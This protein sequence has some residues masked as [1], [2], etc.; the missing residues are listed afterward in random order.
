MIP[1]KQIGDNLT[2]NEFNGVISLLRDNTKLNE[3]IQINTST[4]KGNYGEY[5]FDFQEATVLDNGI[6]IT[7][8]TLS[9]IGTVKLTKAVFPHSN[10]FLDLKIYSSEDV[11]ISDM[12]HSDYIITELTIPLRS[13]MAVN[14][15]F[16]TLE[17]NNIIDFDE[18]GRASCRERV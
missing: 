1:Y 12:E 7:N 11:G 8:E 14:I 3:N 13:D 15:P 5:V 9:T 18:I 4:V 17:M 10:Y 6:L 16:E 2:I